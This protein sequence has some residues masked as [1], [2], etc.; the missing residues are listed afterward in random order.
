MVSLSLS[1]SLMQQKKKPKPEIY[2]S[3]F[4]NE[5]WAGKGKDKRPG[6]F[7]HRMLIEKHMGLIR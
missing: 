5:Q 4:S 3:L 1:P 2:F 6:D 7:C